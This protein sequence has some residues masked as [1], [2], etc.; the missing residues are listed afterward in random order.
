MTVKW[1]LIVGVL[2]GAVLITAAPTMASQRIESSP[3]TSKAKTADPSAAV[4]TGAQGKEFMRR[5]A[6]AFGLQLTDKQ[7]KELSR[8]IL[9]DAKDRQPNTDS[10][11]F[12]IA[13]ASPCGTG[14]DPISVACRAILAG[15]K[16]VG[17]NVAKCGK[18]LGLL[19]A[20]RTVS[21]L[22]AAVTDCGGPKA[23]AK[24]LATVGL[25]VTALCKKIVPNP[26]GLGDFACDIFT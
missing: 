23:I 14:S 24:A 13:A 1:P 22:A 15:A 17:A 9:G 16:K 7:L 25:T 20:T 6:E 5:A 21:S 3:S 8:Q 4:P 10:A 12:G 19:I 11:A 2:V 18:S 26:F